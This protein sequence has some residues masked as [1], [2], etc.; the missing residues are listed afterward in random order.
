MIFG[1]LC[2]VCLNGFLGPHFPISADKNVFPP[3]DSERAPF[4]D[5]SLLS[6]NK[7][8]V[9][10]VRVTFLFYHILK[11]MQLKITYMPRCCNWGSMS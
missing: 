1:F 4:R 3:L 11:L 9:G 5:L 8:E 10:K 6:G 2:L 7:G